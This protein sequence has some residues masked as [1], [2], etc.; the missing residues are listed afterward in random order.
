MGDQYSVYFPGFEAAG[1][2]SLN[3]ADP[4][5]ATTNN[6]LEKGHRSTTLEGPEAESMTRYSLRISGVRLE[7]PDGLSDVL[8]LPYPATMMPPTIGSRDDIRAKPRLASRNR[9]HETLEGKRARQK[10]EMECA[11]GLNE[12]DDWHHE[13]ESQRPEVADGSR[14]FYP[15]SCLTHH[16]GRSKKGSDDS[17]YCTLFSASRINAGPPAL[18][19]K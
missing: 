6:G 11:L 3:R 12:V 1:R 7:D 10:V 2:S 4:Y 18:Q 8:P 17:S 15:F 13:G 19:L 9:N 14:Y 16:A 5:S